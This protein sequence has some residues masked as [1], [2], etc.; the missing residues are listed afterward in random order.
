MAL[1]RWKKKRA[2]GQRS[3]AP[4]GALALEEWGEG[5]K[6]ETTEEGESGC[7]RRRG[8]HSVLEG[9]VDSRQAP[10]HS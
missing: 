5:K 6:P 8:E 4:E 1:L 3:G 10:V 2:N 7:G 9:R